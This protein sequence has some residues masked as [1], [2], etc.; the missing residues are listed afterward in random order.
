MSAVTATSSTPTPAAS[1]FEPRIMAFVCKWCTYAGA[2]LAGTS[3]MT[4]PA[5]V[6]TIMLPCT[7]RIDVSFVLRAFLQRADGVIVS[8]CHPGDC[9][10]TAGN[11]RARRRWTLWRDLLDVLGVDLRRLEIAWISA[12][13][14][15]KWTQAITAFT[16]RIRDLG[17]YAAM[18]QLAAERTGPLAP[19]AEEDSLAAPASAPRT[20]VDPQL[21][22]VVAE[23]LSSG[24]VKGVL[25]WLPSR[26]LARPRPAWITK[27]DEASRLVAPGDAVN[28]AGLLKHPQLKA[29]AP[30]GIIAR[31]QELA[32]LN[33]LVQEAQIDP[34]QVIVFALDATGQCAG[35]MD[36]PTATA[37]VQ[38][39]S[40]RNC[41]LTAPQ[42]FPRRPSLNSTPSWPSPPK[43]A[44]TSGPSSRPSASNAMPAAKS[45]RCVPAQCFT[46]KNQPQW[47]PTAADGPGNFSWH[48]LRAFHLA[49]RCVGCGACQAACPAGIPLNL[50]GAALARS[51]LRHF[52]Y[53]AGA[54]PQA[55]PLQADYRP[56]DQEDFI[57]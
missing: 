29:L 3:R 19:P 4:Y 55:P 20:A 6:R 9:H 27:A 23:W 26:T 47:F 18:H 43:R 25:G 44:G 31:S 51:A 33:V 28:L 8:G 56:N 34:R 13:E 10:Y 11:Y 32:A 46:D 50:L 17:P 14:G 22:A 41:P 42:A 5:N 24:Q 16:T 7:G 54:D 45:A 48:V 1:A 12:A 39:P 35:A 2:D 52:G 37:K 15:A 38:V 40:L 21:A 30:V 36:L 53:R 49:G 57:L